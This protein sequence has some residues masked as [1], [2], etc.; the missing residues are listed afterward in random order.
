MDRGYTS[1][2]LNMTSQRWLT[3]ADFSAGS[4]SGSIWWHYLVVIVPDEIKYKQ[5][6]S[7]WITGGSQ[8][9]GLPDPHSEDVALAAALAM[10]TGT[11]TGCLFQVYSSCILPVFLWV[12]DLFYR[13]L[14]STPPSPPIL[15]R[16]PALKTPSSPSPGTTS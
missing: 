16:S 1:Y 14:M 9:S 13:S 2:L 8:R 4:E 12:N 7:L 6:A 5:N 15:S 3:D 11:I 10:T